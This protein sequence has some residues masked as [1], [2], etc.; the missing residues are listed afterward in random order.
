MKSILFVQD[1]ANALT[2]TAQC[3]G[4]LDN[5]FYIIIRIIFSDSAEQS[6]QVVV[7]VYFVLGAFRSGIRGACAVPQ[8]P[9]LDCDENCR[10]NTKTVAASRTVRC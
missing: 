1:V 4:S 7:F 6:A 9:R 8:V 2:E 5:F 3:Q 10:E